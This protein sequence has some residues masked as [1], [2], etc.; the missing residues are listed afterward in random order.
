MN[1][2]KEID[3]RLPSWLNLVLNTPP[4]LMPTEF[5]AP[6]LCVVIGFKRAGTW[7]FGKIGRGPGMPGQGTMFWNGILE[8]RFMLPFY[9]NLMI[10]W[11]ATSSPSYFQFQ[12]GWKLNGRFAIAFRFLDDSSAAIGVLSPNTDQSG[13]F[14]EGTA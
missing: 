13:G 8:I 5:V 4:F 3:P 7:V 2:I 9:V 1:W 12:F 14:N 11:S 6:V 10:R